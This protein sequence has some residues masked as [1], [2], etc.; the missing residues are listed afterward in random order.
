MVQF[1]STD[2]KYSF[3]ENFAN[4]ENDIK[5]KELKEN[6][7]IAEN[8]LDVAK[9]NTYKALQQKESTISNLQKINKE[10]KTTIS[11]LEVVISELE[12]K[13]EEAVINNKNAKDNKKK[14]EEQLNGLSKKLSE[15]TLKLQQEKKNYDT[16]LSDFNLANDN[17][18][19]IDK[20]IEDHNSKTVLLENKIV[21][22]KNDVDIL[23][24][25]RNIADTIISSKEKDLV[26][27]IAEVKKAKADKDVISI[28][29]DKEND[30]YKTI[31]KT[32][33]KLRE[34]V[35]QAYNNL[36]EKTL[37]LEI[38]NGS[39][40]ESAIKL[41]KSKINK[42]KIESQQKIMEADLEE[43]KLI[44]KSQEKELVLIEKKQ[45]SLDAYKELLIAKK[46][47]FETEYKTTKEK[48]NSTLIS[49][50]I[51]TDNYNNALKSLNDLEIKK[52]TLLE[53]N[54]INSIE[55]Q[56][57]NEK[58][59]DEINKLKIK[60]QKQILDIAKKNEKDAV[61]DRQL[62]QQKLSKLDI[63]EKFTNS[64][65][66]NKGEDCTISMITIILIIIFAGYYT[67]IIKKK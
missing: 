54:I 15:S 33:S 58:K 7:K 27:A 9:N 26:N 43:Y 47:K 40:D 63:T 12:L 31:D 46:D 19:N 30:E 52:D 49:E 64:Y 2:G 10:L 66:Y 11:N 8:E 14:L 38:L 50:K 23:I 53:N 60:K 48:H 56:L 61:I 67:G 37:Y 25:K 62:E 36:S 34:T 5:L 3:Y 4:E 41:E 65:E 17:K 55:S 57:S 6:I 20:F 44:K 28:Q 35:I 16:T 1:Y 22:E 59:D 42:N 24:K 45:N 13:K 51:A 39:L 18:L 32:I 21:K 29:L